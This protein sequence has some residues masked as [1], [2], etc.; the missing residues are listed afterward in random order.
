MRNDLAQVKRIISYSRA[1]LA[2]DILNRLHELDDSTETE[3]E[4]KWQDLL[5]L[6]TRESGIFGRGGTA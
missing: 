3:F 1:E 4:E 6:L 5:D 2:L